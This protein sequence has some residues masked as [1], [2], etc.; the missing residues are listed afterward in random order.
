M[1][2]VPGANDSRSPMS[3]VPLLSALQTAATRKPWL[4]D[5]GLF[6]RS[7]GPDGAFYWFPEK[8]AVEA[9]VI[10]L[11]NLSEIELED[12]ADAFGGIDEVRWSGPIEDLLSGRHELAESARYWFWCE[13]RPS[14]EPFVGDVEEGWGEWL[15]R[16]IDEEDLL[17]FRE[18]L[19][20]GG[21]FVHTPL[22]W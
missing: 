11:G 1:D 9:V 7:D 14:T 19:A 17:S 15:I 21:P 5:F 20:Q 10:A 6:L 12:V 16:A 13:T 18:F 8:L 3:V 4:G 2:P 22:D